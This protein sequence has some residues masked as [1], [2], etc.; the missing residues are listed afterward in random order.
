MRNQCGTAFRGQEG[1]H[2]L[3]L[4]AHKGPGVS[5]TRLA[6]GVMETAMAA[7]RAPGVHRAMG[8][9]RS[10]PWNADEVMKDWSIDPLRAALPWFSPD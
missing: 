9:A 2:R 4:R 1:T 8:P 5:P 3:R 7:S 6:A 10:H